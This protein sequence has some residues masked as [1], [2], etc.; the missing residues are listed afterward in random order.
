MS[1]LR[2]IAVAGA[3]AASVAAPASGA[4]APKPVPF[5]PVAQGDG[6]SSSLTRPADYVIRS[7]KSWRRAWQA[8][9]RGVTPPPAAPSIDFRRSM[10]LLVTQGY[11]PTAGYAIDV[12]GVSKAA[13]R[14]V[15]DV[16]EHSPGPGCFVAQ[17][18]TAPYDVVRV[19]R[20]SRVVSFVRHPGATTC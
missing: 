7:Q 2:K 11:R 4:L 10:L 9:N 1:R 15:V 20:S 6:V 18:V 14:L 3:L 8:L 16:E 19:P 12:A 5:D 13:A 17:H